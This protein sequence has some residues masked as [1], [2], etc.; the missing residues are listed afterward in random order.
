MISG[1]QKQKSRR[2]F[3]IGFGVS[4]GANFSFVVET[5]LAPPFKAKL[6]AFKLHY[7]DFGSCRPGHS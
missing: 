4:F 6:L 7:F 5:G 3:G 2:R 1:P